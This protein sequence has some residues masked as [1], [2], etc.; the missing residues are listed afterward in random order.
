MWVAQDANWL[1]Y[2]FLGGG[3]ADVFLGG[4]GGLFGGT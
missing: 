3:G 4:A 1:A 2:F